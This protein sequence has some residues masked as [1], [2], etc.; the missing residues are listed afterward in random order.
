MPNKLVAFGEALLRYS[1]P[2]RE[3][4]FQTPRLDV[5]VAGAE[6]NV[7]TALARLGHEVELV[8]AVPPNPLGDAVVHQLR[9]HGVSTRNLLRLPG[10]MGVY[11]AATGTGRRPTEITYDRAGSSFAMAEP[12]SWDWPAIFAGASHFHLSGITP[13]LGPNGVA[14]ALAAV[15]AAVA[16]ELTISFDGNFRASLWQAWDGKPASTLR[17]LVEHADILFG[18]HRDVALMLESDLEARADRAAAAAFAAFPRLRIMAGT[19]REVI[20]VDHHRISGRID[21]PAGCFQTEEVAIT[22]IV[23]RIGAGDAYAAG[24]LHRLLSDPD[25]IENA[26]R[27]GLALAALKHSM[28]GDAC[29]ARPSD[30]TAFWENSLD[31]KR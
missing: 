6:A 30:L 5:W 20:D 21:T 29:L 16:A 23:D 28:P 4:L 27:D 25:D 22:S 3:M 24:V 9:G 31:V 7:A 10:R 15:E 14:A 1:P 2:G 26:A 19:T 17:R 12:G 11:Y 8:S 13:A 18:N